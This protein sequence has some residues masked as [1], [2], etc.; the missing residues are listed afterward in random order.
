[1]HFQILPTVFVI[2]Y[3]LHLPVIKF[4]NLL[5]KARRLHSEFEGAQKHFNIPQLQ[6]LV[7]VP[8]GSIEENGVTLLFSSILTPSTGS[9]LVVAR[10]SRYTL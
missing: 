10:F 8:N 1:M 9:A 6:R 5:P 4:D 7:K 2:N 3:S